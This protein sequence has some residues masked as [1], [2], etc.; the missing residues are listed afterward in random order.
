M[1]T[2]D[3]TAAALQQVQLVVHGVSAGGDAP[4][5]AELLAALRLLRRVRNDLDD[6]EP[7]IVAAA[8][9]GGTSW[10]AL[11]EAMGLGS[12]Q[13]AERR[14][15]RRATSPG[16]G[17]T[18][19]Q[20]VRAVRDRRAGDRAVAGWARD[21]A[22]SLRRLAGQVGGLGDLPSAGRRSMRR[23]LDALGDDDPAALLG[24][25]SDAHE[26]LLDGHAELA[27][28]VGEVTARTERLRRD[29]KRP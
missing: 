13:A 9:S 18:G 25:L 20:R 11:A 27:D 21:N 26:H 19:E 14:F 22:R 7:A 1:T 4:T 23:V 15:L 16:S 8:R 2:T 5:S 28:E 6:W 12:R 10:A 17:T 29:A 24:P 3:D